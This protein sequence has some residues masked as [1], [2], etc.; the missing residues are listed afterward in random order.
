METQDINLKDLKPNPFQ[1]R[2]AYGDISSLAESI[3]QRGL[4]NPICVIKVKG[5]GYV[6]VSGHRRFEAFRYLKRKTIPAYIRKESN[7]N[8]LVKDIAI[9]NLQ[10]KDLTPIELAE[11]LLQLI[12]TIETVRK[13]PSR[14]MTLLNQIKLYESR[15]GSGF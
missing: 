5:N 14:A 1:K 15:G 4:Q 12:Y 11:T 9:E 13:E 2:K 8:D 10:R 7:E 3:A 6:I